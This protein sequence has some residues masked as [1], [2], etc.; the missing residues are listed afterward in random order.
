MRLTRALQYGLYDRL[1]AVGS[2]LLGL[3]IALGAIWVGAGD[4]LLSGEL[5]NPPS[6]QAAVIAGAGVLAGLFVWQL[7]STAARYRTLVGA[8][9]RQLGGASA[10]DVDGDLGERIAQLESDVEEVRRVAARIEQSMRTEDVGDA[11]LDGG[12]ASG[13]S[14]SGGATAEATTTDTAT[15]TDASAADGGSQ[16][17]TADAGGVQFSDGDDASADAA[18]AADAS[19]ST[20]DATS[21]GATA[22]ATAGDATTADAA[23]ATTADATAD[24]A[25]P[26]TDADAAATQQSSADGGTTD[27]AAQ[28][29]FEWPEEDDDGEY[30]RNS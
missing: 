9:E 19:G 10:D 6:G 5:G 1:L 11:G 20:A 30:Y 13:G 18:G 8:T 17:T 4:W 14:T 28:D 23:G 24:E 3:A 21:G 16:T 27:D 7:G 22:D 25:E 15:T 2:L 29:P 12:S 26:A